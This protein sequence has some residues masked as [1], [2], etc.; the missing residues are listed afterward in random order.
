MGEKT[1]G[2]RVPSR[3]L[4]TKPPHHSV[5]DKGYTGE[6]TQDCR[7][8]GIQTVAGRGQGSHHTADQHG[9]PFTSGVAKA[10]RA[11]RQLLH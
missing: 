9:L 3:K 4:T 8:T 6:H 10:S 11:E 7:G 1:A 5:S 2:R